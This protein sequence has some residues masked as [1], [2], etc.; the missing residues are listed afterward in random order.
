MHSVGMV[1]LLPISIKNC[2]IPHKRLDEQWH[3]NREVLNEVHRRLLQ[4]LTFQENPSTGS[5]YYNVIC[6]DGNFRGCT[7][8][9]AAWLA[10][11][12]EYSVLYYLERHV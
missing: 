2:N 9:L 1:A 8:V 11:C 12:P 7:P 4:P 5:G 6:A 3:T 10:D